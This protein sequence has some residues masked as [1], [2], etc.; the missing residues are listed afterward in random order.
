MAA[1]ARKFVPGPE[2]LQMDPNEAVDKLRLA[3]KVLGSFKSFYFA[4][5]A[6][7]AQ[8]CPANPWRFQNSLLFG[9]LDAFMERCHDML[10]FQSTCLQVSGTAG[11]VGLFRG[12]AR[13]CLQLAPPWPSTQ[14]PAPSMRQPCAHLRRCCA[15]FLCLLQFSKLERVEVGGTRGKVLSASIKQIYAD[16]LKAVEALQQVARGRGHAGWGRLG[17]ATAHSVSVA[18]CKGRQ[19]AVANGAVA[20]AAASSLQIQLTLPRV[21]CRFHMM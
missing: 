21:H 8:D 18:G 7:S 4:Y 11:L 15:A 3:L 9:R 2:L 17:A 20:P 14:H 19:P 6:A 5:K 16:F 10:D 1:Q 12:R 13:S